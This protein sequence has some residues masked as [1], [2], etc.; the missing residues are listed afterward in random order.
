V[1]GY[2]P[3]SELS[4]RQRLELYRWMVTARAQAD[5]ER[6]IQHELV[7]AYGAEGFGVGTIV[8]LTG[9]DRDEVR[10]V[11]SATQDSAVR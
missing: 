5:R 7:R 1:A 3:F 11:L 2:T 9:L 4:S 10:A 8:G 6:A